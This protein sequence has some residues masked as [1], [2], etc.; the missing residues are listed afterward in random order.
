MTRHV[1]RFEGL[2]A[3]YDRWREDYPPPLFASI[4]D[5]APDAPP[6]AADVGA[7]TG[8][9][10]ARLLEASP[11]GWTVMAVEPGA[12]MRGRL[13]ARFAAEPRV[14]VVAA[15]GEALPVEDGALAVITVCAAFHWLDQP[16]FMAEA[17][18]ALAPGG[19]LAVVRNN[20]VEGAA[21]AAMSSWLKAHSEEDAAWRQTPE[22]QAAV[23]EAAPGFGAVIV[24]KA[25]WERTL[26]R[27]ALVALALT[28]STALPALRKLG[29]E[30]VEAALREVYAGAAGDAPVRL[31]YDAAALIVRRLD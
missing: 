12:D 25:P 8:L 31:R 13:E 4:V 18:R 15:P 5:E 1:H 24:R 11:Q 17:R 10:T 29:R 7:G 6:L 3:E 20:R 27:D 2:A 14:R 23:L 19:V 26:E 16:T 28:R 22:Q 21:M 30:A 9:A